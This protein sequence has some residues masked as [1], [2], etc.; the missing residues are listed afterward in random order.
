MRD[1]RN[2]MDL[3]T[4]T[5]DILRRFREDPR[6]WWAVLDEFPGIL[7]P[8]TFQEMRSTSNVDWWWMRTVHGG[9]CMAHVMHYTDG[10]ESVLGRQK[11]GLQTATRSEEDPEWGM[12]DF[13]RDVKTIREGMALVDEELQR[14]GWL[15]VPNEPGTLPNEQE[16]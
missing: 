16:G 13:R 4:E 15:L 1:G 8:W 3:E 9:R 12:V 7:S 14:L 10:Y 6:L 2:A 11:G 5:A